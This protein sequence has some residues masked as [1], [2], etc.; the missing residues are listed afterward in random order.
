MPDLPGT[1]TVTDA[2]LRGR[3]IRDRRIAQQ[4]QFELQKSELAQQAQKLEQAWKI[5]ENTLAET[6]KLHD[7][8]IKKMEADIGVAV[9]KSRLE[10]ADAFQ[11]GLIKPDPNAPGGWTETELGTA[12]RTASGNK[13]AEANALI[14]PKIAEQ[15]ALIPGKIEEERQK[16]TIKS[17]N[18]MTVAGNKAML[19]DITLKEKQKFEADQRAK[20]REVRREGIKAR[21]DFT[22]NNKAAAKE[23]KKAAMDDLVNNFMPDVIAGRLAV[24]N[25]AFP[26]SDTG[27]KLQSVI[28]GQGYRLLNQNQIADL[29]LLPRVHAFLDKIDALNKELQTGNPLTQ[30]LNPEIKRLQN[31][32]ETD[33][34]LVGRSFK[35]ERGT[36]SDKDINRLRGL[37]PQILPGGALSAFQQEANKKANDRRAK[38]AHEMYHSRV[39]QLI[40]PSTKKEQRDSIMQEYGLRSRQTKLPSHIERLD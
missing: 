25:P 19:D 5:S 26:K 16:G 40:G 24:D 8:Q 12:A 18:E 6:K 27:A 38:D 23:E 29:N 33:L 20:D 4:Q 39:D 15:Q 36:V 3:E 35:G 10:T 1:T 11:K 7:A 37:I 28:R 31:E 2:F 17:L 22:L 30:S 13:V 21:T 9:Q 34:V 14:A 32:I